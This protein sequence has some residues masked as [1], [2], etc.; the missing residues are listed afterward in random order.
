MALVRE[1]VGAIPSASARAYV[2]PDDADLDRWTLALNLFRAGRFDSCRAVLSRF[3]YELTTLRDAVSGGTFDVFRERLPVRRGWGT[4]IHNRNNHKRLIVH[5]NH[6]VDD[7]NIPVIGAELFRRTGSRWMLIGGS[8]RHAVPSSRAADAAL[9]DRSVFQRWHELLTDLTQVAVSLHTYRPEAYPFPVSAADV[10]IS[11]G[12]TSDIQWGISQISVA[13]RDTLR[14]AGFHTALAMLDSGFARLAGGSNPQGVYSNDST[15]F[16][17]WMN[18]EISSRVR[19]SPAE[20]MRFIGA[21]DRALGITQKSVSKQINHAFGL[22]SPR[23]VRIDK[24][25]KLLFPPPG[26]E[27]YRIV[28]FGPGGSGN[29]TLDLLL[30]RWLGA[31]QDGNGVSRIV[32]YDTAGSIAGYMGRTAGRQMGGTI[33]KLVT[34]PGTFASGIRPAE[35]RPAD[36]LLAGEESEDVREPLQV[37]RIPLQPVIASTVSPEYSPVSTP[38]HW[39]GIL[40]EGYTPQVFTFAAASPRV[41]DIDVSGLS[42]FLIPLLRNSYH[43]GGLRFVGVDMTDL[44]VNEIARLVSE[45]RVEGEEIDLIAEEDESGDYYLRLF[46]EGAFDQLRS[47]LP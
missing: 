39:G 37:Y 47:N 11:N 7:G 28:S 31:G 1:T 15:G 13:F 34:A 6:P 45:Y 9:A 40:P 25:N 41:S 29:D 22:V 12:R 23:V 24:A 44:L 4:L 16:G 33:T 5:V 38:F 35:H 19:H 42:R 30:G 43:S 18:V 21:A 32:E 10:I 36:S 17:H 8:A 2:V 26:E 20:Y 3:D 14:Y 46:P 27:K